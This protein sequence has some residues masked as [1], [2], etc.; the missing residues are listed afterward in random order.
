[1]A[2]LE[3]WEVEVVRLQWR[4]VKKEFPWTHFSGKDSW[5]APFS[6][7]AFG[8]SRQLG[9][10]PAYSEKEDWEGELVASATEFNSVGVSFNRFLIQSKAGS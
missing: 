5:L 10:L 3:G 9:Q 4:Q 6:P 2:S 1:M 8:F 7:Q